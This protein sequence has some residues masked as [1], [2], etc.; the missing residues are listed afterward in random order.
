[1]A[2]VKFPF[3][4]RVMGFSNNH[5]F[6]SVFLFSWEK[7]FSTGNSG[8]GEPSMLS[9]EQTISGEEMHTLIIFTV[10][11]TASNIVEGL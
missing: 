10:S 9:H 6:K 8:T 5:L 4:S 7:E 11:V 1:M 2:M 3:C